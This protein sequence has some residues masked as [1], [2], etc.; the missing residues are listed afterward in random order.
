MISKPNSVYI[1]AMADITHALGTARLVLTAPE[2]I[3]RTIKGWILD[4]TLQPGDRLPP[5]HELASIF[6]VSRPTLRRALEELTSNEVLVVQRGRTGGHWVAEL[7]VERLEPRLIEFI[8][9]SLAAKTLAY[10]DVLEVRRALEVPIARAAAERRTDEQLTALRAALEHVQER[11]RRLRET[12]GGGAQAVADVDTAFHRALA[13]C[14]GNPLL[15][16]FERATTASI[17]QVPPV[18]VPIDLTTTMTGLPE[19]VEAV[20]DRD[21]DAA[22]A[23]MLAHITPFIELGVA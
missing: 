21:P 9:M 5:E 6:G 4:G 1:S 7:S 16:T 14:T 22:E 10:H 11:A 23:A 17:H 8:T 18:G 2:Q 20:A 19:I 3:S 15:V 13:E 12:P